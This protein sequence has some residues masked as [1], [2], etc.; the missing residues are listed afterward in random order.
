MSWPSVKWQPDNTPKKI[1]GLPKT[2]VLLQD[3]GIILSSKRD[4]CKKMY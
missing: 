1:V 4:F 3:G 2:N